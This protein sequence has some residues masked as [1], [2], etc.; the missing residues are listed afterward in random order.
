MACHRRPS[1]A[2]PAT[3]LTL[4]VPEAQTEVRLTGMLD[5]ASHELE[6]AGRI[7]TALPSDGRAAWQWRAKIAQAAVDQGLAV[8]ARSVFDVQED[9]LRFAG[10]ATLSFVV[11]AANHL[12][13]W[14]LVIISYKKYS[15]ATFAAGMCKPLA[16]HNN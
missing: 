1:T 2:A 10:K 9:G 16:T 5:R 15:A 7:E 11:D 4:E 14:C 3:N 6:K 8:D 12:R 13:C